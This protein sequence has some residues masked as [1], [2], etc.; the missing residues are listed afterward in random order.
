MNTILQQS[1]ARTATPAAAS[2]GTVHAN[3]PSV[4]P[5]DIPRKTAA[6]A[7]RILVFAVMRA[8]KRA[9]MMFAATSRRPSPDSPLPG[10]EIRSPD[11]LFVGYRRLGWG[12]RDRPWSAHHDAP[13]YSGDRAGSE[14]IRVR[15]QAGIR[16]R[17]A[18]P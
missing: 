13:L 18:R 17:K 5:A 14:W 2:D 9:I 16:F 7:T 10:E 12:Y 6:T 1:P 11:D 4:Q 15:T 8:C 3:H